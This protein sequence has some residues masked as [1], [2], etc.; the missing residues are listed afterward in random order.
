MRRAFA[1]SALTLLAACA[2]PRVETAAVEAVVP[3][4]DWRTQ[5][6]AQAALD[7]QWWRGFG[8]PQLEAVVER[9]LARNPDIA[10]AVGRIREARAQE[11]NARAALLPTLDA[12][13]GISRS[14][15]VNAFGLPS[16]A[17]GAQPQVSAAWEIDLFGRLADTRAAAR[18]Q[19]IATQAARDATRLSV[20][21]TAAGGY[22]TLLALDARLRV[23]HDTLIARQ[24][25]LRLIRRRVEEG[26]SPK[27]ELEQAEADYQAAAKLIPAAQEAITRQE[28]GLRL[29]SGDLPGAVARCA[30]LETLTT[31]PVPE[32]LPSQL[33]ARRPDV[34]QAE[35]TLAAT[36][37]LL[38]AARKRFLPQLRL[39]AAAGAAFS[40]LLPD[41]ITIWSI[42]GSVLAPLFEGGRLRASAEVAASQRD[43]AAENYRR[44]ALSAFREVDD[45]L[46]GVVS[47]DE[48]LRIGVA[49]RTA[50]AESYRLARNRY[51]AGYSPFLE[52]LDAQRGLL[53]ADLALVQSRSDALT[54]RVTLYRALGGGWSS[55]DLVR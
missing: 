36:D 9:A 40:S 24:D 35:A 44:A 16:E 17:T 28:N 6:P 19:W 11:L 18:S 39:S 26:Y 21:S 38:A 43:Q 31:A 12:G 51:R 20:A 55:T 13:G 4:A 22:V 48:Q 30:S 8:D 14:R 53:A 37:R 45:A 42:G 50:L 47:A 2:G 54:A 33:L 1:V 34:A 46:A 49:Q 10:I 52:E 29:L 41:P 7:A 15:S 3:P 27:L 25:S 23:A 32:G 5:V